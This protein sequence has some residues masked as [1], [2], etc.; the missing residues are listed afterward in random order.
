MLPLVCGPLLLSVATTRETVLA[1]SWPSKLETAEKAE[2]VSVTD[3]EGRVRLV[4]PD[5]QLRDASCRSFWSKSGDATESKWCDA[6]CAAGYCPKYKCVCGI[7]GGGQEQPLRPNTF[8]AGSDVA[9]G[10][11]AATSLKKAQTSGDSAPLATPTYGSPPVA[12]AN[13]SAGASRSAGASLGPGPSAAEVQDVKGLTETLRGSTETLKGATDTM[14]KLSAREEGDGVTMV[15]G[16]ALC[17]VD[18]QGVLYVRSPGCSLDQTVTWTD[19]L[20][21]TIQFDT[22]GCLEEDCHTSFPN[23]TPGSK[24][25]IING[26]SPHWY[27]EPF[28]R[29]F[30][31]TGRETPD[32][33]ASSLEHAAYTVLPSSRSVRFAPHQSGGGSR[34][35]RTTAL[36]STR[37]GRAPPVRATVIAK[38]W[39]R[40]RTRR[41]G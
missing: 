12:N 36:V 13:S 9:A 15:P 14:R 32:M 41:S 4:D 37:G 38:A 35:Q 16:S 1:P 40:T 25:S 29:S 20:E 8:K 22:R 19:G 17:T 28:R 6:N 27:F 23:L 21:V 18:D 31:G 3:A 39:I 5:L 26:V 2:K 10:V 34:V 33:W 7:S 24:G 30:E 11:P